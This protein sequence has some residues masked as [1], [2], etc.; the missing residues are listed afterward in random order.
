VIVVKAEKSLTSFMKNIRGS[1]NETGKVFMETYLKLQKTVLGISWN[2]TVNGS[3]S[4][5]NISGRK[6]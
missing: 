4:H 3:A 5:C 6:N 1:S 2:Y